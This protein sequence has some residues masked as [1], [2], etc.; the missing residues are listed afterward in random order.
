M[1]MPFYA[2]GDL[3]AWLAAA[4]PPLPEIKAVLSQVRQQPNATLACMPCCV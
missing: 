1:Q 4:A 3:A 2:G